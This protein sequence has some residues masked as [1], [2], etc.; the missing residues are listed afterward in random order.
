[1]AQKI[2]S[3]LVAAALA[4]L[5]IA[6]CSKPG[7]TPPD[8][9]EEIG[10]ALA[11]VL[12]SGQFNGLQVAGDTQ[13]AEADFDEVIA[14]MQGLR[15]EVKVGEIK[16][17]GTMENPAAQVSLNQNYTFSRNVE[18]QDESASPEPTPSISRWAFTSKANLVY[19]GGWK[20]SWAPSI[21]H[22]QL[23]EYTRLVYER[24]SP[25]RGIITDRNG[26]A[27]VSEQPVYK[28]GVDKTKLNGADG[29]ESARRLAELVKVDVDAYVS[30]FQASGPQAFV[31]ALTVR[32]EK[33]PEGI[34]EIPGAIALGANMP[35]APSENFAGNIFGTVGEATAEEI[36]NSDGL[37]SA[38][39]QVGKQGLQKSADARLR[40][41][42]GHKISLKF[43]KSVSKQTQEEL[44]KPA[45]PS[46]EPIVEADLFSLSPKGGEAVQTTLNMSIQTKLE[47]ALAKSPGKIAVAV[48]DKDGGILAAG[49]SPDVGSQPLATVGQFPPGSTMKV[50]SSLALLRRGEKP[51]S[52]VDCSEKAEA[53]GREF[54]NYPGYPKVFIGKIS[55]ANALAQ[56]CN[57]AFVNA[58][59]T[60]KELS[61]AAA[62]LGMGVDYD[63]GF[64]SFYGSVP[65]TEDPVVAAANSFGQGHVLVSPMALAAMSGSVNS[66][67]SLV[68][69]LRTDVV[70][71]LDASP[72]TEDEAAQLK[73]MME[74]VL[75][76][77][78]SSYAK[79]LSGAKTGTAEFEEGSETK[80][81]IWVTG[82]SGDI[83]VAI[84]DYDAKDGKNFE[85]ILTAIFK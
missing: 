18:P 81:H 85:P 40:G 67:K 49:T 39:D 23:D 10:E 77:T 80:T 63:A 60:S 41:D 2:F 32:S 54:T 37:L 33:L 83:S 56:S 8:G 61:S 26:A 48:L 71:T 70:P 79:W 69:H 34:E 35:L 4:C 62:S 20:V 55:L 42:T 51:T 72:I 22:P 84:I 53:G 16:Y 9:A 45:T 47:A 7:Y 74:G 68:A 17:E 64:D 31:E 65:A 6:G 29:D 43:R 13:A 46:A 66:G 1:M 59:I 14:G 24:T 15:P 3:R 12:A 11:N 82:F 58:K 19:E 57:T 36:K 44:A 38:G 25:K 28:V 5:F 30:R 50:A 73:E 75:K 76:G 78:G 21:V 52:T 27:I